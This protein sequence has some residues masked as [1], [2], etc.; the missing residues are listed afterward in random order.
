MA[1]MRKGS[2]IDTLT[3]IPGTEKRGAR[4]SIYLEWA[5]EPRCDRDTS[6]GGCYFM[7]GRMVSGTV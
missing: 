7:R 6:G 4:E 5:A 1:Q 2:P 3:Q